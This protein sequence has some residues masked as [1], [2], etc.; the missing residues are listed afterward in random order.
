[1]VL[2]DFIC[3]SEAGKDE[4][5]FLKGNYITDKIANGYRIILYKIDNF[6]VEVYQDI[7]ENV[8]RKFK[9]CSRSD[10]LYAQ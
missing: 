3:L 5:V 2:R 8:I 10:I 7:K 9:G 4:V 6:Y 1:M